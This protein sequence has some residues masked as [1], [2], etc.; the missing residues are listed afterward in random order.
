MIEMS[1]NVERETAAARQDKI[2]YREGK[3]SGASELE[4]SE[5]ERKYKRVKKKVKMYTMQYEKL[6]SDLGYQSPEESDGSLS[7]GRSTK[8]K[9]GCEDSDSSHST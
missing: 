5:V 1:D 2:K 9:E 4:L 7:S 3:W 8:E 6:K